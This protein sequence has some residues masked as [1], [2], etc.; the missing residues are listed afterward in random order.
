MANKA[1]VPY[2]NQ[3]PFT[4]FT[5]PIWQSLLCKHLVAQTLNV[6]ISWSINSLH[7]RGLICFAQIAVYFDKGNRLYKSVWAHCHGWHLL[8]ATVLYRWFPFPLLVCLTVLLHSHRLRLLRTSYRSS[9]TKSH[10]Q[11]S[12]NTQINS[13]AH[14][15][16]HTNESVVLSKNKES[17]FTVTAGCW[18]SRLL[19]NVFWK[20]LTYH[21]QTLLHA[22]SIGF[23]SWSVQKQ[24]RDNELHRNFHSHWWILNGAD[25]KSPVGPDEWKML[26]ILLQ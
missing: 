15:R 16:A 10:T 14:T 12:C 20:N 1:H 2:L 25:T 9:F 22:Q 19:N 17:P 11:L 8:E 18:P 13:S 23:Q 26:H 7:M 4:L 5:R 3:P 21:K 6:V 24:Q